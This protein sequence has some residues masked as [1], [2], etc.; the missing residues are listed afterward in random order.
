MRLIAT[1]FGT[2]LFRRNQ[3]HFQS[4]RFSAFHR[5]DERSIEEEAERKI[6]WLFKLIFAGTATAVAYQFMPYMGDNVMQ[7]SVSLLHVKDPLFKRM[8]ASRLARFAVDDERRMKIVEMGAVE[9]LLKMLES[10]KDDRTRIEALRALNAISESD[11][12]VL[13][14]KRAGAAS[15]IMSTPDSA[16]DDAVTKYK[17]RLLNRVGK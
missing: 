11:G 10:A 1:R 3:A 8:G 9:E 15:V 4:R 17:S 7:Q 6:G 12:A 16:E 5:R 13:E 14:F 2:S